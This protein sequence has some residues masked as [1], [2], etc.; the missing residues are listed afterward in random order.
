M[1]LGT[2]QAA[3]DVVARPVRKSRY[4]LLTGELENPRAPVLQ[5]L[6]GFLR[7]GKA[8]PLLGADGAEPFGRVLPALSPDCTGPAGPAQRM[9]MVPGD[10]TGS[11]RNA[12][13]PWRFLSCVAMGSS[14][15]AAGKCP[16]G[17]GKMSR[18]K[19]ETHKR[20][21]SASGGIASL[22]A[23]QQRAETGNRPCGPPVFWKG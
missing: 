21:R 10:F 20:L 8:D 16:E 15:A 17:G 5:E 18:R 4:L 14:A 2:S 6:P 19:R 22:Y 9:A 13:G 3:A 11:G 1:K 7:A 23:R 12:D